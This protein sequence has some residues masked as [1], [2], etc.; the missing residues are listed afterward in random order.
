[1]IDNH[2]D[3]LSLRYHEY[4]QPTHL[5]FARASLTVTY[6]CSSTS[7][8]THPVFPINMNEV[9]QQLRPQQALR[10]EDGDE[11]ASKDAA[12]WGSRAGYGNL[13]SSGGIESMNVPRVLDVSQL[14]MPEEFHS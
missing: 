12:A 11:F 8:I 5:I 1:M 2:Y 9:L 10:P 3:D 6:C 4:I 7:S 14:R 13:S